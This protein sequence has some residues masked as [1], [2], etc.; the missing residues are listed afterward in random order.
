MELS[1]IK[2][3]KLY[4]MDEVAAFME[5]SKPTLYRM[6]RAGQIK[7]VNG[8]KVG[9]RLAFRAED[10]QAYYDKIRGSDKR[11]ETINK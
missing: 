4:S 1:E 7:T 10:I 8:A 6:V 2:K 11:I 3:P 5:I 9:R